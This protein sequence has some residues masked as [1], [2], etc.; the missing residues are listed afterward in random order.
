MRSKLLAALAASALVIGGTAASAQVASTATAPTAQTARAGA[1]V[2]ESNELRGTTGWIL[3][4]VALGLIIWGGIELFGDDE[5][6][7]VS[8]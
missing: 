8:P 5:D 6:A 2:T 3:A 4:A 1:P 7:P